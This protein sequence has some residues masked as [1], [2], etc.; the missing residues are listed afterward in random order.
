MI[1]SFYVVVATVRSG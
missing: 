1:F